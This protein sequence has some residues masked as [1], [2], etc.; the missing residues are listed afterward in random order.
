MA[1]ALKSKLELNYQNRAKLPKLRRVED[2]SCV[3]R[4]CLVCDPIR[5]TKTFTTEVCQEIECDSEKVLWSSV[6][7]FP[8]SGKHEPN[9]ATGSTVTKVNTEHS[10][11][12]TKRFLRNVFIL[13][14]VSVAT[15]ELMIG[16]FW[17]LNNVN[18]LSSWKN[19]K[20]FGNPGSKPLIQ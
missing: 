15:V 9:F 6:V 8:T 17:F 16:I 1:R 13:T 12:V 20:T 14:I 7:K 10:E 2:V 18:Y 3:E 5:I 4:N 19:K 11:K